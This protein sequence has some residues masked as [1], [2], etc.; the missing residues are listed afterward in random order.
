MTLTCKTSLSP[1]TYSDTINNLLK[2]K[3]LGIRLGLKEFTILLDS[4]GNPQKGLKAILVG[5][6]N[7]KGST[8]AMLSS[9]LEQ[10]GYKVGLYTSP[11]LERFTER[12]KINSQEIPEINIVRL[13]KK[14]KNSIDALHIKITLFEFITAMAFI[15]F[16]ENDVDIAVLEVGLGGRLDA[17]NVVNPIISIITNVYKDHEEYL[18]KSLFQI[19]KEKAGIIK[20]GGFLITGILNQKIQKFFAEL[21]NEINS[22]L[23]ILGKNFLLTKDTKSFSY[24]GNKYKFKMLQTNLKGKHQYTNATLAIAALEV[25]HEKGYTI[26]EESIKEGL[27]KV[28]WPGRLELVT[29]HLSLSKKR[30]ISHLRGRVLLDCAHNPGGIQTL[31]EFLSNEIEFER[32]ILVLGILKNKDINTISSIIAPIANKIITTSPLDERAASS[33][34]I[35]KIV[36]KYN[37]SVESV[38][39]VQDACL[40]GISLMGRNDLLCVT[41][42]I[43]TVGEARSFL[44]S[45]L[46]CI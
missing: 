38:K 6:T 28:L 9:I 42:S 10:S 4:L 19:G 15:Y 41:G 12:I 32:L 5:G 24:S 35:L 17:T 43:M 21:C 46:S 16:K 27:Q 11:H 45:K 18:G 14:I 23:S 36:S 40:R 20:S 13:Y 34:Y 3:T 26:E 44:L 7:G 39:S 1:S 8:C 37:T 31:K 2:L 25:L 30:T 22:G 29:D 33:G